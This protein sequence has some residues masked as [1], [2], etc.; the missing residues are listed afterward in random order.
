MPDYEALR[1][2]NIEANRTLL[3]SL[4]LDDLKSF[5][6]AAVSVPKVKPTAQPKP[7]KPAPTKRKREELDNGQDAMSIDGDAKAA[8]VDE[9]DSRRRS[10]RRA[11]RGINYNEDHLEK[12]K[13]KNDRDAKQR[14][15]ELGEDSTGRIG[16]RLGQRKHDPKRFGA[17]PGIEVGTWWE[18]R[19]QCSND[20]IHAPF[21]AGIF[22]SSTE[23]AYSVALSGGYDDDV[24]LGYAFT[25]T[26]SGGRDLK[27]TAKNPK[28]LRTAPQ[29]SDQTFDNPFNA[30]LK[31]SSQTKKPVRVIRGYK[32]KSKYAPETGYR[33][34]GLYVVE[35][36][37]MDVGMNPQGYKVVKFAFKRLPGQ[38]PIPERSEDEGDEE[39][40]ERENR[41]NTSEKSTP[42]PTDFDGDEDDAP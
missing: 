34:D 26:G 8:R 7:K 18:T 30:A 21:V 2:K 36:A 29:S 1:A 39:G 37:W 10:S 31:V 32:L 38:P 40:E 35:K 13:E 6:P 41:A 11:S 24:D 42:P 12:L 28:N 25:Y 17:I 33:Y 9:N 22:G 15:I 14:V 27:G 19:A 5:P 4:G 3:L 16:N 23:G 20:A